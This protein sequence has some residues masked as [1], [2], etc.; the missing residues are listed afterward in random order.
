M[1]SSHHTNFG[2]LSTP[3]AG[4]LMQGANHK[5]QGGFLNQ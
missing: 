1:T 3:G 5:S 4:P 2:T